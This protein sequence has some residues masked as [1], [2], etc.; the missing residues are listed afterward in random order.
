MNPPG[1]TRRPRSPGNLTADVDGNTVTLHWSEAEDGSAPAGGLSYNLRI[2]T[3]PGGNEAW[4]GHADPQT[5]ARRVVAFGNS[6]AAITRIV[7]LPAGSYHWSVQAVDAAFVGSAFAAEGTFEVTAAFGTYTMVDPGVPAVSEGAVDW[8]DYDGDGDLDLCVVGESDTQDVAA[9]YRNDGGTFQDL[10]AGLPGVRRAAARWGDYDNDGDLDLALMGLADGE[11]IVRVY[12]NDDGAFVDIEADLIGAYDGG[13]DWGDYDSDGDLDLV[14]DGTLSDNGIARIY[15][16]QDGVFHDIGAGLVGLAYG[17]VTWVDH[18]GDGDLDLCLAGNRGS[19]AGVRTTIYRNAA[20]TFDDVEADLTGVQYGSMAWGDYD[21]DGDPDL[22]LAGRTYYG[23]RFAQIYRNSEGQM[24]STAAGLPG[25]DHGV[26]AWGD[27]D[28]DGDLDLLLSGMSVDGTLG[29]VYERNTYGFDPGD[30]WLPRVVESAAAWADHDGDGDLD[31]ILTGLSAE[32]ERTLRLCRNDGRPANAP[33]T[34][35]ADLAVT[36]FGDEATLTWGAAEDDHTPQDG[37]S[38]NVRIGLSPGDGSVLSGMASA[39]TGT[40]FVA[41][42]GNAENR[43]FSKIRLAAG[44]YHWSV[45]AI[46]NAFLGSTFAAWDSFTV[47][48]PSVAFTAIDA[49]LPGASRGSATW[50]DYDG[51]GDLDLLLTGDGPSGRF[52]TLYGNIDGAYA[53]VAD[54][55]GVVDGAAAWADYDNDGDLDLLLTGSTEIAR[56]SWVFRNDDG[57]FTNDAAGLVG[58]SESA[59]AWADYDRDG[60]LD[61]AITGYTGSSGVVKVYES[62]FAQFGGVPRFDDH[63]VTLANLRGGTVAWADYDADGDLD[64]LVTGLASGG[65]GGGSWLYRNDDGAFEPTADMPEWRG[66]QGKGAWGD[67]DGDGDPDLLI[68]VR[69]EAA[70][71]YR[72]DDGSFVDTEIQFATDGRGALQWG[73]YDNDGDL[74]LLTTTGGATGAVARIHRNEGDGFSDAGVWLPRMAVSTGSWG[75]HDGDGDLDLMLTGVVE[76]A[77]L[78]DVWRNDGAPANASP[79]APAGL[80]ARAVLDELV[81]SWSPATDDHTPGAALSYNVRIGTEPGGQDVCSGMADPDGGTRRIVLPGNAGSRLEWRIRV[82]LGTYYWSVQAIDSAYRASEFAAEMVIDTAPRASRLH[83]NA[84]NPFNAGTRIGYDLAAPG[85]AKVAIYDVAGRLVRTLV[86]G[87]KAAGR[88][89]VRWDGR[90][91][92]GRRVASGVYVCRM[93]SG[94]FDDARRIALV[95]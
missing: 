27:H 18:D 47:D 55:P 50:G 30:T 81:L 29:R 82:P 77:K 61:L 93:S 1:R 28:N 72:N 39:E 11:A 95:K 90:D 68:S 64:L 25:V 46:D 94:S 48:A 17:A 49:G 91:D 80:T 87:Q 78:G 5:G 9:V 4:P 35:P 62:S 51:D 32:D 79:S 83:Q 65:F 57:T 33:P 19:S 84:P 24:Q 37:L 75:D 54:F 44:T 66:Y 69:D 34:A 45:Q 2:G 31:L 23:E 3:T 8:G 14:I 67:Y 85:F 42:Q 58:V 92:A 40:R 89:E 76:S 88:F 60:D 21:G 7:T 63:G 70:Y 10:G 12:R 13:L 6:Q 16:N 53:V 73:D 20:G 52:A 59:M 15:R 26:A 74:D 71:L 22:A 86:N 56:V 43:L 41:R 38:Y 36:L